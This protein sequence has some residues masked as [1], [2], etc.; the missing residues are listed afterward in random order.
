MT[1]RGTQFWGSSIPEGADWRHCGE[2]VSG[3]PA[4]SPISD[5]L[6]APVQEESII[7]PC[8]VEEPGSQSH[9][10]PPRHVSTHNLLSTSI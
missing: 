1:M 10:P 3:H 4:P 2:R 9:S 8:A 5:Q 6:T 7:D